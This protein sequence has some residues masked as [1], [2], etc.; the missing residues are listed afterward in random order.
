MKKLLIVSMCFLLALTVFVGCGNDTETITEGDTEVTYSEDMKESVEIPEEYPGDLVPVY[1]DSFISAAS[2][3]DDGSFVLMGFTND[4]LE[5]VA[6]YYK[7]ELGDFQTMQMQDNSE[8][9]VTMG[10]IEGKTYTITLGQV[11]E[12]DEVDYETMFNI[13]L[14]E[15]GMEL[16]Q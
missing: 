8:G 13:V 7:E 10:V 14:V 4:S 16:D 1:K 2:K 15:G 12:E 9:Y 5:K 3:R 11:T 6:E